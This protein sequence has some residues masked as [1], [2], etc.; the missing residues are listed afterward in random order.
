MTDTLD[1]PP[2]S[3]GVTTTKRELIAAFDGDPDAEDPCE[4]SDFYRSVDEVTN[5]GIACITTTPQI[6]E[7]PDEAR[8]SLRSPPVGAATR[9]VG[10]TGSAAL[11]AARKTSPVLEFYGVNSEEINRL[12]G[13]YVVNVERRSGKLIITTENGCSEGNES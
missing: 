3:N 6:I 9:S 11:F 10:G 12:F 5:H 8:I 2:Q 4:R 7:T 1:R 13:G